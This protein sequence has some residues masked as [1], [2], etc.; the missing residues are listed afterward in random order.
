MEGA[1][2]KSEFKTQA[3]GLKPLN[4]KLKNTFRKNNMSWKDIED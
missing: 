4:L 1:E 3:L 2:L